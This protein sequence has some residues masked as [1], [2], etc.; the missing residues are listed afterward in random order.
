M[1]DP[2][3]TPAPQDENQLIAE[4]REKLKAIRQRQ[5]EG[6]GVAFPNDFNRPTAATCLPPC[7][8]RGRVAGTGRVARVAGRM[9]LKR[10]MGKPA[11][12][13]CRTARAVSRST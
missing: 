12:P 3:N 2:Q 6:H 10:V 7:R 5:A 4:R 11:S 8:Q 1:S 13:H 9:M